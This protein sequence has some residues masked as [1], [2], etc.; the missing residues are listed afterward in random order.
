MPSRNTLTTTGRLYRCP[1]WNSSNRKLA[2]SW[3]RSGLSDLKRMSRQPSK[4]RV[5]RPSGRG[6]NELS[7]GAAA[8]SPARLTTSWWPNV[9]GAGAA[10][11][12]ASVWAAAGA[13]RAPD[14]ATMLTSSARRDRSCMWVIQALA[15]G[16]GRSAML[17]LEAAGRLRPWRKRAATGVGV[18]DRFEP[19]AEI[20]GDAIVDADA[21]R[22]DRLHRA[23]SGEHGVDGVAGVESA[24]VEARRAD[25]IDPGDNVRGHLAEIIPDD[26]GTAGESATRE[27]RISGARLQIGHVTGRGLHPKH[28]P[29]VEDTFIIEIGFAPDAALDPLAPPYGD[30][31]ANRKAGPIIGRGVGRA[32]AERRITRRRGRKIS[33]GDGRGLDEN[34]RCTD[35]R[36]GNTSNNEAHDV[37]LLSQITARSIAV[38]SAAY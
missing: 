30:A 34:R 24:R 10:G 8:R 23:G 35:Q 7:K 3:P 27:L 19:H 32:V 28:D 6:G 13:K 1:R 33:G 22:A 14:A 4:S 29:I 9:A 37:C 15:I 12:G 17:G 16:V 5:A 26:R 38:W 2:P 36:G 31:C 20:R 11:G 18:H 25:E 21:E